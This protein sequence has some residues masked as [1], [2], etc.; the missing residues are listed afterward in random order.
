MSETSDADPIP[1]WTKYPDPTLKCSIADPV[2]FWEK[3]L[4]PIIKCSVLRSRNYLFTAPAPLFIYPDF[5][6]G[7]KIFFLFIKI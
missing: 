1:L 7:P 6:S 3:F 2:Q 5:D 4:D